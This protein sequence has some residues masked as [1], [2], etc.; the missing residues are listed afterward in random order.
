MPYRAEIPYGCYWSTPFARWQG[1]FA[2]LNAVEFAAQVARSELAKRDIPAG[3]FDH[4][5]LGFSVPQK[6]SFYGLPWLAGMAGMGQVAGPTIM[7]ACATAYALC[8]PGAQEIESG[9]SEATL[10]LTCDRTSQRP[11]PV[12]PQPARPGGTGAQ[13]GLVFGQLQLRSA[14]PARDVAD[15]GERRRQVRVSTAEHHGRPYARS[16]IQRA[17]GASTED[18]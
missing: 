16:A 4:G 5:V 1:A 18:S 15:R 13:R 6:H 14:R 12:L 7:Q 9:L 11:A 3:T 10:S 17:L 8:S 2:S